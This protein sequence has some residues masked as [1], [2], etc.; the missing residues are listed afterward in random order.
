V[1][2]LFRFS[3]AGL[4]LAA[5]ATAQRGGGGGGRGG[6]PGMDIQI[7]RNVSR[8][9]QI[10]DY[11]KLSKDQKKEVKSIL[12]DGQKQAN[13]VKDEMVKDR[14]A[15]AEA[16]AGGKPQE[17]I[18]KATGAYGAASAQMTAIEMKSFVKVVD[19]LDADQ[20]QRAAM[21][22]RMMPG[23]FKGKSWENP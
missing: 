22:F 11:L 15:I 2:T 19:T 20:K 21:L 3:L 17:E 12:D 9:E 23:L 18:D 7:P 6:A 13:P 4:L 14:L 16:V 1:K 5:L 10:S 8:L